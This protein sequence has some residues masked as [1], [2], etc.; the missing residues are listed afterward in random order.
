MLYVCAYVYMPSS[1]IINAIVVLTANFKYSAYVF[2]KK[3]NKTEKIETKNKTST[4]IS[5]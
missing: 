1:A 2:Y 5:V 3:Q 4:R